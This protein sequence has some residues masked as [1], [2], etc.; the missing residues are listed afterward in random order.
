MNFNTG[1]K[2][3]IAAGGSGGHIFPAVALA[4]ELKRASGDISI[5]FA[6]SDKA[7][8]RRIFDKEGFEYYILS[9]NKMPYRMSFKLFGFFFKLAVDLVRS[10]YIML[11]Y[12]PAV[13]VGFGGYVPC[14]VFIAAAI[15]GVPRIAHEQNAVPGRANELMFRLAD[16]VAISFDVTRRYMGRASSKALLT[17]N[18]IRS[19][20]FIAAGIP[21]MREAAGALGLDG[22]KFTILVI[23]GSQGA[24]ALNEAFV[25]ALAEMDE[26]VKRSVQ[27][28][29]ITGVADYEWAINAYSA[30]GLANKVFSFVDRIEV[31]Y[32]AS[33]MVIT[34]A[35]ASALFELAF[36]GKP[37]VLVPYPY[38]MSHQAE[39]ARVFAD[40][41][42]AVSIDE[43]QLGSGALKRQIEMLIK[44]G[45][46][47]KGIADR[48]KALS[49]PDASAALAAEVM[50]LAKGDNASL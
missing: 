3:L 33:N 38:A 37:M 39:N 9:A 32:A 10:L 23:G 12:R 27:V 7:L 4:R 19:K 44:D 47:L 42:A 45:S 46:R 17:G 31:A 14:P 34:R 26:S 40:A 15:L 2:I 28:I 20:D 16:K 11:S 41:G 1:T 13:V 48:A 36:F 24:R 35:G 6:G 25:A 22:S 29:H 18:P 50:R 43:S 49:A 5:K 8:D 30:M 21:Q